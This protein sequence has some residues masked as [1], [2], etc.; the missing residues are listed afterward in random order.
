MRLLFDTNIILDIAL[1]REPHYKDSADIFKKIDNKSI[2]GFITATTI[3]DI[4]YIAK[5]ERGHIETIDFI[6]N[7]IQIVDIV[8]IDREI[9]IN[10]LTS[11]FSDFEDA[12]QSIASTFNNIDF[13]ITRNIKDFSNSEIK[14]VSPTDFLLQ[15]KAKK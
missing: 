9:I 2:F 1:N 12:I 4:Y 10:S 14:A 13:I 11:Q 7:L 5:K 15:N 8:G 6:A 3:T